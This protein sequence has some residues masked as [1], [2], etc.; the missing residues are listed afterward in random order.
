MSFVFDSHF[1]SFQSRIRH[2]RG[3]IGMPASLSI[4]VGLGLVGCSSSTTESPAPV[5]E[6]SDAVN[7]LDQAAEMTRQNARYAVVNVVDPMGTSDF[8][9][10]A[11]NS[12]TQGSNEIVAGNPTAATEVVSEFLDTIRRGGMDKGADRLLTNRARQELA[13]IGHKLQ[14]LG[15]PSAKY[16]VTRAENIP[17]SPGSALVHSY[18]TEPDPSELDPAGVVTIQVVWAVQFEG[19][20]WRISGLAVSA[21]G[22]NPMILDF[23]NGDAMASYLQ[24]SETADSQE[25]RSAANPSSDTVR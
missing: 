10:N 13:R 19:S 3:V 1:Q 7:P 4:A 25:Q 24:S 21:D 12:S 16:T 17:D 5:A 2:F 11:E 18:W 9:T 14:P 20:A 22:S 23:E 6:Q 15:T 8:G